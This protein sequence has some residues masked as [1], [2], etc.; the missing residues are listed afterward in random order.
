MKIEDV[1]TDTLCL[2]GN[3]IDLLNNIN[4]K[5]LNI[6]NNNL[7][8]IGMNISNGCIIKVNRNNATRIR[9]QLVNIGYDS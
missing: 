8:S 4:C 2:N 1:N 6:M 3:N 7:Y 5:K 9:D